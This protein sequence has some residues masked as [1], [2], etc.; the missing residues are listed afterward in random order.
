MKYR[1]LTNTGDYSFGHGDLDF[2]IDEPLAVG[3]SVQ[4]RLLLWTGEWFLNIDE[5]TP[6]MVGVLGKRSESVANVTI[7]DRILNTV[8][9]N[10]IADYTSTLD[11]YTRGMTISCTLDTIYGPTALEIS[12]YANY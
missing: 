5:G 12:N 4:T 3:Q 10:D 8:G 2:Y 9:V 1:K 7:Q 11:P 6:Y